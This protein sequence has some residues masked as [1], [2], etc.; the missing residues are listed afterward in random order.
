MFSLVRS[1]FLF[2]PPPLSFVTNIFTL[3]FSRAVWL[4]SAALIALISLL[5]YHA[6]RWELRGAADEQGAANWS[7]VVLLSVGAVCQQGA[8][9]CSH[10]S[11]RSNAGPTVLQYYFPVAGS[12]LEARGIAGR[13]ISVM[14][15][16]AVI[17]LYT[18]YAA[19]IVSLLQSTTNSIRTL[20][21][22]YHSGMALGAKDVVYSRHF[23]SVPPAKHI[24]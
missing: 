5:L 18:S 17:F 20:E 21:D 15:Y 8:Y 22:L 1:A 24:L 3:P 11:S 16:V 12:T 6:F 7:D 13:T 9:S 10:Y 23:F 2:R 19:C 14:L 4:I